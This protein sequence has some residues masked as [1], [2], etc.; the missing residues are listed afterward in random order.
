MNGLVKFIFI[1]AIGD[2]KILHLLTFTCILITT[3]QPTRMELIATRLS[4][5]QT[6]CFS[7]TIVDYLDHSA[8]L[9]DFFVNPSSIPGIKKAI[10]E[11]KKFPYQRKVLV[12]ELKRQYQNA[13]LSEQVNKNIELLGA[14]NTFTFTTAHQNNIFTGPLYFIYKILHT[15]RLAE[16]CKTSLPGYNFVPVFYMGTEDADLDE[17]N[18]IHLGGEK[19]VWNTKQSGAV[20]RMKIDKELTKLI[21]LIEGQL[22]VLPSG[23]EI[24]QLIKECYTEGETIQNA[25]FKFVHALFSDHGLI[26]LLPDNAELKKQ[27]LP[28]FKD[29]LLN[30]TASDIVER[31]AA[32]L[33][34]AGYKVQANPREINLFYLKDDIRERIEYKDGEYSVLSTKISFTKEGL[35][36]EIT[37]HPDRFSPNVILR[38]LYQETILPNL[39][40]VGGG[41]ETAYWLQ[42]K[43]LFNHYNVP[44]PILIL[45]NSFMIVEKKWQEKIAKLGFK[46][47]DF[48]LSEQEL[49]NKLV[50]RDSKNK[51]KL[52]GTYADAESFYELIKKQA[53]AIDVSLEKH[54]E[55]LKT[56]SVYRLKELEKKMLRAE[57]RK[58]AD[59]QRQ[60]QS[61]K[62]HLFPGNGLQERYE[63]IGYYYA[64]W[65][66]EFI[67]KLYGNSLALEQEFVILSEV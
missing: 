7:K 43:D 23:K 18:H 64:K 54:V 33:S 9:N 55:A 65:G 36:K 22:S 57:K 45:R 15:I 51:T 25:T 60:I 27:M 29:D 21:K 56:Q 38:G 48:F 6:G 59:Q 46:T 52:N 30:Q 35:L 26:V 11:R 50:N 8:S 39:A 2:K 53:T 24:I 1:Y 62:T 19:L 34:D 16:Y 47:E 10:E 40:F 61:I 12:Q 63:N 13:S 66:K 4:Y 67:S 58:F 17:L 31:T 28:V 41:G 37:G 20:G 3:T 5:R 14:E 32:K 44:Y 49:L 42:L